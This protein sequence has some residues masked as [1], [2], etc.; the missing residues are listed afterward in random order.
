MVRYNR[1]LKDHTDSL[2]L[3]GN[4]S[5]SKEGISPQNQVFLTSDDK[6]YIASLLGRSQSR[7]LPLKINKKGRSSAAESSRAKR[8][9]NG[10]RWALQGNYKKTV[11]NSPGKTKVLGRGRI[12]R[13]SISIFY[14]FTIP[15]IR[16]RYRLG[17]S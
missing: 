4:L 12:S 7:P 16:C 2:S 1:I 11:K 13:R 17:Y 8:K 10:A 9:T 3:E 15:T 14:F 6:L 5:Y